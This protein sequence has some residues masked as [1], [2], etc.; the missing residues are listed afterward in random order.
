MSRAKIPMQT[1][2]VVKSAEH[3]ITSIPAF[4]PVAMAAGL[5]AEGAELYARNLKFLEE[6]IRIRADLRP[7]LATP[8]RV[9]LDL[10]TM[11]LRDYGG[12]G[13]PSSTRPMP[14]IAPSSP[15]ITGVRA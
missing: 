2:P 6:E 14:A 4:W 12:P 7:T 10:R 5:A 15:I 11:L 8:N 3:S 13:R 1:D 9:R